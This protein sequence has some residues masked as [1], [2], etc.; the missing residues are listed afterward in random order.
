LPH[1]KDPGGIFI[2]RW[3]IAEPAPAWITIDHLPLDLYIPPM[4]ERIQ[5]TVAILKKRLKNAALPS[6]SQVAER[7]RDPFG[8]LV[9]TLIS[10][11]T[12]DQVTLA[13]SRRL[14]DQAGTPDEMVLLEPEEVEKLIYP[15]GFFRTKAKKLIEIA[16]ILIREHGS[17]VP[18][19]EEA[20]LRLP[21]VGRKT[22]NLVLNLG[23]G[24]PAVCVDTH[25]HRIAN[26]LGWVKAKKPVDT[27]VQLMEVLPRKDWIRIN[28]IL[29]QFGQTI[30][31]PVGPKCGE[32]PVSG[33][34][35][36]IGVKR[37]AP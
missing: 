11:R 37:S 33:Y 10:L 8:I 15:A 21:G 5:K 12:K 17:K 14:L 31:R 30:C 3:K 32:C 22:A 4:E 16:R 34:C 1:A 36:R 23:S 6:V 26:R 13:A 2:L 18:D 35:E 24:K 20:L 19:K 29:V 27:E 28:E 9:S 7:N 25:V